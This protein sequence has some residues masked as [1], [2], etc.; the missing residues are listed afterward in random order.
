MADYQELRHLY[1]EWF[2]CLVFITIGQSV[3]MGVVE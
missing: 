3:N 2:N 1:K